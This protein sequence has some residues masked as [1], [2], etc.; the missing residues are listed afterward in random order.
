MSS[1]HH[2]FLFSTC[3]SIAALACVTP[4]QAGFEW[5]P[6][7]K[8]IQEEPVIIE[9]N[10]LHE[11]PIVE[12]P[13]PI[14]DVEPQ[15]TNLNKAETRDSKINSAPETIEIIEIEASDA[16]TQSH[17]SSID[18]LID[19][20]TDAA[21]MSE[22]PSLNEPQGETS[23]AD[24]IIEYD[25]A[26]SDQS[27][28]II[29]E[30]DASSEQT[31]AE[32]TDGEALIINL[33]PNAEQSETASSEDKVVLPSDTSKKMD[34]MSAS[35]VGVKE[36]AK[37]QPKE[38]ITWNKPQTFEVIEG[39]GNEMPLALV[40]SQIVPPEYA[41]SF[42][43]GVNPGVTVSWNGGKPWNEV[44]E[45]A[46]EPVGINYKIHAKKL[47]LTTD[48]QATPLNAAPQKTDSVKQ[49]DNNKPSSTA[50]KETHTSQ[51]SDNISKKKNNAPIVEQSSAEQN[52]VEKSETPKEPTEEQNL[53][54]KS[55]KDDVLQAVKQAEEKYKGIEPEQKNVSVAHEQ[56][57]EVAKPVENIGEDEL[58]NLPPEEP[59]ENTENKDKPEF[60]EIV[61]DPLSAEKQMEAATESELPTE[62]SR[63]TILDPGPV[64]T[65]QPEKEN[66]TTDE[67]VSNQK[68]NEVKILEN[69]SE[70]PEEEIKT[71]SDVT[72]NEKID[73]PAQEEPKDSLETAEETTDADEKN[74]D[75][76]V[77]S[78]DVAQEE[79][80]SLEVKDVTPVLEPVSIIPSP[81]EQQNQVNKPEAVK[82]QIETQQQNKNAKTTATI[83]N[84]PKYRT[85]A[86]N[87]IM[88]WEAKRG[89]NLEKI[90]KEWSEK[91][92]IQLIWDAPKDYELKTNIF[93]NGT[94]QNAIEVL[95]TKGLKNAPDFILSED[96]E[97]KLYIS[98]DD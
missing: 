96:K 36:E 81:K 32:Q 24:M 27:V 37:T 12:D 26:P 21:I 38:E 28:D 52:T 22:T 34:D 58:K 20:E 85:K 71:P 30:E 92:N 64:E 51:S 40:L 2:R 16:D 7:E 31:D 89:K 87:K 47:I 56:E 91:E 15:E 5:T 19:E 69:T 63:K 18:Q 48:Q 1:K 29:I 53:A 72:E 6:P 8:I 76:V 66:L 88:V 50:E 74:E 78:Q 62:L 45:S 42:G 75:V 57:L 25:S 95:F 93:I 59:S 70:I 4:T 83:P 35:E 13:T 80:L 44:L 61:R 11:T 41:Y 94:F 46:L 67:P 10:S 54:P 39:F 77:I 23:D 82:P 17:S 98:L 79:P 84:Q 14:P 55:K 49:M 60:N 33:F 65:V 3:L 43:D 90:V 68:K 9:E 97:Y 86:S 73:I